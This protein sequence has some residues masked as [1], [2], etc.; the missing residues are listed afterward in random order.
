MV[1]ITACFFAYNVNA[2]LVTRF[3]LFKVS[4]NCISA[5]TR[6]RSSGLLLGTN[7]PRFQL[8]TAWQVRTCIDRRKWQRARNA[9]RISTNISSFIDNRKI[10]QISFLKVVDDKN[11]IFFFFFFFFPF[12][13]WICLVSHGPLPNRRPSSTNVGSS[14]ASTPSG[15]PEARASSKPP[16]WTMFDVVAIGEAQDKHRLQYIRK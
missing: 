8:E 12:H 2:N 15:P 7:S 10:Q 4:E 11:T 9:E 1:A 13:S 3:Q 6:G 16:E 14:M 5:P